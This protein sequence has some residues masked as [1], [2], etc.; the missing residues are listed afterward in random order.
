MQPKVGCGNGSRQVKW[1]RRDLAANQDQSCTLAAW[2]HPRFSSKGGWREVAPLWR[3]LQEAGADVVLSGHNHVYERFARQRA[4]GSASPS[5]I[6]QFIVGTGGK[7]LADPFRRVSPNSEKRV[8]KLGVLKLRLR[9]NSYGWRFARTGG[10]V[11]DRGLTAC[12][13]ST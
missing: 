1:L 3:T 9:S 7:N 4:N 2:H 11:L 6:R 12:G 8:R 10:R 13:G 5:G